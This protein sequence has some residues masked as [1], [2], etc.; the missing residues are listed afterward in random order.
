MLHSRI[1]RATTLAVSAVQNPEWEG[2]SEPAVVR[3]VHLLTVKSP[4]A[5]RLD[6]EALTARLISESFRDARIALTEEREDAIWGAVRL[7]ADDIVWQA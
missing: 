5:D 4:D 7:A 1:Q 3:L 6:C 2:Y